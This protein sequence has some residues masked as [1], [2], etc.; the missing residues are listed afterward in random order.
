MEDV[1]IKDELRSNDVLRHARE[2]VQSKATAKQKA[3]PEAALTCRGEC[4]DAGSSGSA[5]ECH[6]PYTL[7]GTIRAKYPPA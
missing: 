3:R 7:D 2:I 1:P 4:G 6:R 5:R